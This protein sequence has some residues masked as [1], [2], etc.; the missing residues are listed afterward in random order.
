MCETFCPLCE[1][2]PSPKS[3]DQ[4]DII[5]VELPEKLTWSS[6]HVLNVVKVKS[7]VSVPT[8][9]AFV[10]VSVT[11]HPMESVAV[12]DIVYKPILL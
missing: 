2:E 3:H 1:G 8:T 11:E 12:R 5:P 7:A 9:T 10:S 6:E 4:L